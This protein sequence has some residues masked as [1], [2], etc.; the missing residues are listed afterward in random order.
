M[1]T[2]KVDFY[3]RNEF[4]IIMLL[5]ESERAKDWINDN[6]SLDDW[7]NKANIAIEPRYFDDIFQA[8]QNEGMTLEAC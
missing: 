1:K 6:I 2:Q 8:L 3:V 7:Q 4:S 5:P